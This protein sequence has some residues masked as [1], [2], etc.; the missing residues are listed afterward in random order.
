VKWRE[1]RHAELN[2]LETR[3]DFSDLVM[4]ATAP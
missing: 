1:S 4:E 2:G 3:P